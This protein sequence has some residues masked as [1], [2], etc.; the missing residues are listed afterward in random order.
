MPRHP[1]VHRLYL[2]GS[3]TQA[4]H[5]DA[6]SDIDIAVQ[7]VDARQYFDLWHELNE[8]APGW[9]IDLRDI[10]KPSDFADAVQKRGE[11]IYERKND[12]A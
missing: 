2:F 3:I 8:A 1:E 11:L 4:G 5:F 12:P 10:G 7:G 9:E 6:D